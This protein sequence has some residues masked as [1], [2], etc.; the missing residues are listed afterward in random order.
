[1]DGGDFDGIDTGDGGDDEMVL[2]PSL[3]L[4]QGHVEEDGGVSAV[5]VDPALAMQLMEAQMEE[6]DNEVAEGKTMWY[7]FV[8]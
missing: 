2:D 1:M 6:G 4:Q 3:L 7:R 8:Q 5:P